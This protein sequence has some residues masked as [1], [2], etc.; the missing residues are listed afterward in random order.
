[1]TKILQAESSLTDRY[2][3]TVPD[4]VRKTLGLNK[5]DKITYV[6]NSDGTVTITRSETLE[7][8]PIL[9]KFLDFL[10]QD[11]KQN[12][13]HIQPITSKTLKRVQSLVENVDIDLNA[14]LSDED[15]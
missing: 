4:I 12:P 11:I 10:A 13:Q 9:G 8:D 15:E 6:I 5:K 7:E 3:T 1:M 2:Q 14:S